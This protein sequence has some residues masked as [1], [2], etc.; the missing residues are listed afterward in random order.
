MKSMETPLSED[1]KR[2]LNILR[3]NARQKKSEIAGI[4]GMPA[5]SVSAAM[6]AMESSLGM[7]Y[8][9]LV[10]Y[11]KTGH[12]TRAMFV[13]KFKDPGLVGFLLDHENINTI[14]RTRE[15]ST[16]LIEAIFKGMKEMADF[17]EEIS[18][19]GAKILKEF[20]VI[21]DLKREEFVI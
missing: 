15:D 1:K 12:S 21:E 7:R 3:R 9:T 13:I 6:G 2:I 20:H 16:L 5:S 8:S 14:L 4:M 19:A 11:R 10:D 18:Q 17:T